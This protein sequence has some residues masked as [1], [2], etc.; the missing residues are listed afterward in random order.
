MSRRRTRPVG[1]YHP[2]YWPTWLGLG[3][4]RLASAL[5]LPLVWALGSA[6]GEF[7]LHAAGGRRRVAE[8]NLERCFPDYGAA[9]RRALL[10]RHFHAAGQSILDLGVAVWASS[11][12]LQRVVRLTGYEHVRR[13]REA[14]RA[15]MLLAPHFVTLPLGALYL[16]LQQ[17]LVAM[18]KRPRH[19][20][21]HRGYRRVCTG[22]GSGSRLLDLIVRKRPDAYP[23]TLVEHRQGLRPILTAQRAGAPFY[24]LPDQD[25]GRRQAV[26]APFFGI[27]A[28]TVSAVGRFAEIADAAV[29]L[30]CTRQLPRGGGYQIE[31]EPPLDDFPQGD[32]VAD[33]T[34]VNLAIEAAVRRMP[35]QYF[36]L[37]RR[38]KTRPAGEPDFYA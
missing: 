35:E 25:L 36:W 31:V 29:M 33:A 16:T 34:R 12:R 24:Y 11:D 27:P 10:R 37:H 32:A 2:G 9:T 28:S 30:C 13:A 6:L 21:I 38:F 20:L 8:R 15:V 19:E 1:V 5:P 18:Y 3:P 26:F 14:G 4:W 7:A 17:P 23:F 22:G